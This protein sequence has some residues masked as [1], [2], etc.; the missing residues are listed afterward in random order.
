MATTGLGI[1]TECTLAIYGIFIGYLYL[2][3]LPR[4]WITDNYL[5][6][7]GFLFLGS[8]IIALGHISIA[9]SQVHLYF[10]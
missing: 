5:G 4:G 7:K 9:L 2:A 3:A 10:S 1:N 8:F 6:Q